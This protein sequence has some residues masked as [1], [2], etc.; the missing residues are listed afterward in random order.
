MYLAV[1]DSS[2]L[3]DMLFSDNFA[4]PPQFLYQ[5]LSLSL[6]SLHTKQISAFRELD[7]RVLEGRDGGASGFFS[8][9]TTSAILFSSRFFWPY[10]LLYWSLFVEKTILHFS[11]ARPN[12]Q[13]CSLSTVRKGA[14]ML[15]IC[16]VLT[17]VIP[18]EHFA[19][20]HL[21]SHNFAMLCTKGM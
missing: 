6:F 8:S 7:D 2:H 3:T 12:D 9:S 13:V 1:L 11:W 16:F 10:R 20:F 14:D 5:L 18:T 4:S 17:T 21:K 15:A 19:L